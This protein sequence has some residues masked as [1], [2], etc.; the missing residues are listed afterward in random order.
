VVTEEGSYLR[1]TDS[2]ITQL[3]AQGP[4]RTCN[5]SEAEEEEAPERHLFVDNL[6]VRIHFII[7]MIRWTG[8]A[9][10]PCSTRQTPRSH[11]EP[12]LDLQSTV[13]RHQF[14]RNSLLRRGRQTRRRCNSSTLIVWDALI[15]GNGL[16]AL[17]QTM[18]QMLDKTRNVGL[19]VDS[20]CFSV[21]S[22]ESISGLWG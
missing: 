7:E 13:R 6:L 2:C 22:M 17:L 10:A 20:G 4:S 3:K 18:Y 15:K 19:K 16:Q 1:L 14:Y 21:L 8:L 12:C 11:F 5:E 9:G